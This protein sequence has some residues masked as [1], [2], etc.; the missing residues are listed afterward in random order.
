[1]FIGGTQGPLPILGG[2]EVLEANRNQ[3]WCQLSRPHALVFCSSFCLVLSQTS[4]VI[5]GPGQGSSAQDPHP[6]SF[7]RLNEDPLSF[8]SNGA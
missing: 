1:M 7:S 3:D 6:G 4:L 8:L 2:G 5:L